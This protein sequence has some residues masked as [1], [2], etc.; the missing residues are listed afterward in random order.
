MAKTVLDEVF[1]T[2]KGRNLIA[3]ESEFS[4]DWLGR[5]ECYLRSLRFN[6]KPPSVASIAICAS[7]LQHYG[8]RMSAVDAYK[9]L[10]ERFIELSTLCHQHINDTSEAGWIEKVRV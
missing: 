8:Q 9:E 5:S 2:L 7:K 10:G 6:G 3:S 4:R 1:D